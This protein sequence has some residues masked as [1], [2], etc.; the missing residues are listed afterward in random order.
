M[1]YRYSIKKG[2][3]VLIISNK[4]VELSSSLGIKDV[5][6]ALYKKHKDL[7]KLRK[8]YS[9]HISNSDNYLNQVALVSF[10][11]IGDKIKV[12]I[13]SSGYNSDDLLL[14]DPYWVDPYGTMTPIGVPPLGYFPP[15]IPTFDFT[16]T[17]STTIAK[18]SG[19]IPPAGPA[20][21]PLIN[22]PTHPDG[23]I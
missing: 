15:I 6:K 11:K 7:L 1:I 4:K 8:T 14:Y 19:P 21:P 5:I 9:I 12:D 2:N 18:P 3:G 17:S 23:N 20:S 10:Y 16:G 22:L 13:Y